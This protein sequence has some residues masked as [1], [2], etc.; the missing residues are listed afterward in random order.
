SPVK[1]IATPRDFLSN[2]VRLVLW[3]G[4][5]GE[6]HRRRSAAG[7]FSLDRLRRI[8]GCRPPR[9]TRQGRRPAAIYARRTP[10]RGVGFSEHAGRRAR[11]KLGWRRAAGSRASRGP[12]LVSLGNSRAGVFSARASY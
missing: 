1:L 10:Q 3:G 8:F 5:H 6:W 4:G 12:A 2:R 11:G 9:Q 7:G